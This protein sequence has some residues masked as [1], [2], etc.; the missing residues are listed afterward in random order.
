M[1]I[2]AKP[3]DRFSWCELQLLIEVNRSSYITI[4]VSISF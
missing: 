3:T 4:H 1:E 2:G